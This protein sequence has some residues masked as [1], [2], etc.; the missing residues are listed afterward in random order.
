MTSRAAEIQTL[1]ADIDK[2]LAQNGKRLPRVLSSQAQEPRQVLERTRDF[3]V[4]LGE[5]ETN[6]S[7]TDN[8]RSERSQSPPLLAKF[9]GHG[10]NQ[11]SPPPENQPDQDQSY[12]PN[13]EPSYEQSTFVSG[14]QSEFSALIEPLRAELEGLL[15]Q[16]ATLVQEIRQLEQRRLQNYSLTQQ[17]ANQEQMISE[18]LQV[19][20]NRLVPHLTPEMADNLASSQRQQF[21]NLDAPSSSVAINNRNIEPAPPESPSNPSLL[22]P[23]EQVERLTRFAQELDRRLLSLDGTVNVVFEAL[24]RNINTYHESLSQALARMH[25]KGVQ[26]EHLMVSF[27]N[28]LTLQLQQQLPI[29]P[30]SFLEEK[31][32]TPTHSPSSTTESVQV[33]TSAPVTPPQ[34][35]APT[36]T[37]QINTNQIDTNQI[38]TTDFEE[39]NSSEIIQNLDAVLLQLNREA[40]RS[41]SNIRTTNN[42]VD[43]QQDSSALI[44]DQREEDEVD[45]LYASLFG[46]EDLTQP[47]LEV[48]PSIVTTDLSP[49]TYTVEVPTPTIQ[50]ATQEITQP[51]TDELSASVTASLSAAT[52]TVQPPT[53]ELSATP[54][55]QP[56][57]QETSAPCHR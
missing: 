48:A 5:N 20:M 40:E 35:L 17:M 29:S 39:D 10:S 18:F 28:N 32:P 46:N 23:T 21:L 49:A 15:Q 45:Q 38:D 4:S 41:T 55:T 57:A 44:R 50:P 9:F 36:N 53:D 24:Q 2:L 7:D 25:S 13:Y 51:V 6:N 1:I 27:L 43:L 37:N 19:L 11:S 52:P 26:G 3:L 14:S 30:P 54:I 33:N 8:Q 34:L 31:N 56:I 16:R 42:A 12:E 22:E 47:S